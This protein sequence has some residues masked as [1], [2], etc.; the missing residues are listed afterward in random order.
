MIS[1][2]SVP[3]IQVYPLTCLVSDS[4]SPSHLGSFCE[5]ALIQQLL[6]S[7]NRSTLAT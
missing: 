3:N 5:W 2:Q 6:L 4:A 7:G 1:G